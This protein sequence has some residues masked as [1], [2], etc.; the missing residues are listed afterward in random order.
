MTLGNDTKEKVTETL[1]VAVI[2]DTVVF[3]AMMRTIEVSSG[4]SVAAFNEAL[5]NNTNVL[6]LSARCAGPDK[7]GMEQL[8]TV[9][10]SAKVLSIRRAPNDNRYKIT[11]DGSYRA[12]IVS[13]YDKERFFTADIES[14]SDKPFQSEDEAIS[15]RRIILRKAAKYASEAHVFPPEF[16]KMCRSIKNIGNLCDYI[17][18]FAPVEVEQ[19][20]IFLETDDLKRRAEFILDFMTRETDLVQLENDIDQKLAVRLAENQKEYHLR[21][22]MA[23]IAKELG[24]NDDIVSEVNEYREKI[25]A[26]GLAASDEAKLLTECDRL[27][28]TASNSAEAAVIRSYIGTC[29]ALPWNISTEEKS[30]I[31]AASKK[32]DRDHYGMKEVKQRILEALS[33]HVLSPSSQGGILCLSG[34]PGVGKTSVARSIAEAMNRKFVRI[35]LGGVKDEAEL[36]GHRKTY[37]GSMPGRIIDAVK[38]AGSNNPLILLDEIDKLSHDYKGDPEAAL[39]EIL[40]SEQNKFFTDHYI[41]IPFDLSKVFFVTTAN[42]ISA[43]SAPLRDRLDIIEVPSYTFEEKIQIAKQHLIKKQLKKHGLNSKSLSISPKALEAIVDGY[44][45]EAGVRQL[46]RVIATLCRKA[47]RL[48]VSKEGERLRVT[49]AELEP[50]LG[51]RRYKK[52]SERTA[53]IGVARGLAWTS[54]GGEILFIEVCVL[55]GTGKVELT[56]SLGDVMKESALAAVTYARKN[57]SRFGID[58][59]FYKSSDIHIHVPDGA[60]P[61]DGPSA[62][63]TITTALISALTGIPVK[64]DVAMTGEITIR[65]RVLAIGGLR[66]KTMAAYRSGISTVL[67]PAENASDIAQISD[68]V[69]ESITFIPV[70]DADEVLAAALCSFPTAHEYTE[71]VPASVSI[72]KSVYGSKRGGKQERRKHT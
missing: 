17:I 69:R 40:D 51:A 22:K 65:G 58:P 9:G 41:D 24:D 53:D 64:N 37:I 1:P 62:G 60:T 56:G 66:E 71:A 4:K 33:V 48:I 21:E 10:T 2:Y 45:H 7:P 46:E 8:A 39:L 29:L 26:I 25:K 12:K 14:I 47:A 19:K 30:D 52:S 28:R 63:I 32:L 50:L 67:I 61:K 27:A 31:E 70:T 59:Y 55:E 5:K 72:E 11:I 43:V 23:V 13:L 57:A 15:F 16:M 34:P 36:R 44:T 35:S 20:Q 38:Q 68:T 3:P 42:D 49:P 54:V 6:V 18:T